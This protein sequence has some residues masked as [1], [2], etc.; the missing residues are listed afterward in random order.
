MTKKFYILHVHDQSIG[1]VA[2]HTMAG[3]PEPDRSDWEKRSQVRVGGLGGREGATQQP[4]RIFCNEMYF[5]HD[6]LMM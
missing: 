6:L 5:K 1:L 2:G 3:R 4:K